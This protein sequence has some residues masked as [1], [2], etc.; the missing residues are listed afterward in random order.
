MKRFV[1]LFVCSVL[2]I[3]L[4]A[5]AKP[6]LSG[7]NPTALPEA[8]PLS[9][10]PT[11]SAPAEAVSV[12][13]TVVLVAGDTT[14]GGAETAVST[15]ATSPTSLP[16]I[17]PTP[18]STAPTFTNLHFAPADSTIP[19]NIF[20]AGAEEIFAVWDYAN[21]SATDTVRRVWHYNGEEWL[22]REDVWDMGQYGENGRISDVSIYNFNGTGLEQGEY[23]L[24]LYI[25]NTLVIEHTFVVGTDT[26]P[27]SVASNT[28]VPTNS[29]TFSNLRFE[30][31]GISQPS[32]PY[33]TKEVFA[34]WDY[35]NIPDKAQLEIVWTYSFYERQQSI[36]WRTSIYGTTGSMTNFSY[37]DLGNTPLE[38]GLYT[39]TVYLNEAQQMTGSFIIDVSD[40]MLAYP[41][42]TGSLTVYVLEDTI[43]TLAENGDRIILGTT[44]ELPIGQVVWFPDGEHILYEVPLPLSEDSDQV[45]YHLLYIV[46]VVTH[47]TINL[48][49]GQSFEENLHDPVISLD[50]R[51]IAFWGGSGNSYSHCTLDLQ[52]HIMALNEQK[53]YVDLYNLEDFT[54]L[55]AQTSTDVRPVG[56][57]YWDNN[58]AFVT[59]LETVCPSQNSATLNGVYQLFPTTL[60]AERISD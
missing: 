22:I 23:T 19:Q 49:A 29:A 41:N 16:T 52:V 26:N 39:L 57:G 47:A 59:R 17:I 4:S 14:V 28:G 2:L 31:D 33:G 55:V 1:S 48:T 8:V 34:I 10:T 25:N 45:W 12:T 11:Q 43:F 51:F 21:M 50:G 37:K 40:D 38:P 7:E 3:L 20:A 15:P 54:G 53:Q 5:C 42:Q 44:N 18:I 13:S 24:F 6:D 35:A 32:F 9:A 30:A 56:T 58:G 46:N 60:Q 36:I 27:P